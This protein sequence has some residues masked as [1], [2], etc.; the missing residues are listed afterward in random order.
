[1]NYSDDFGPPKL[2]AFWTCRTQVGK[3]GD[4]HPDG[5]FLLNVV[6]GREH[7]LT[8]STS[9]A[10]DLCHSLLG[11]TGGAGG[12]VRPLKS[13]GVN[14]LKI[15]LAFLPQKVFLD[16]ARKPLRTAGFP[17]ACPASGFIGSSVRPAGAVC[18]QSTGAD[19][20]GDP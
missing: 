7:G 12:L 13:A 4:L 16:I 17:G 11:G 2:N 8:D 14:E 15:C 10:V 18:F 19:A 9:R 3:L 6:S 5:C 20:C 1:M